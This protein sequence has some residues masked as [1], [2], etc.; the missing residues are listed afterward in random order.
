MHLHKAVI[1]AVSEEFNF[2]DNICIQ[3]FAV[4]SN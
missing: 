4:A 1:D 3:H 2:L